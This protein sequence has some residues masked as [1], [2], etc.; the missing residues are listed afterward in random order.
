MKSSLGR[1]FETLLGGVHKRSTK[2]KALQSGARV[3]SPMSDRLRRDLV[4]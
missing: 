3:Q 4:V 1:T 2:S